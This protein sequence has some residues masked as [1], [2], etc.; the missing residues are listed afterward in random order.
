MAL[1]YPPKLHYLGT[2]FME[3]P[4]LRQL[5]EV[6]YHCHKQPNAFYTKYYLSN[7]Q[8][9]ELGKAV[10]DAGLL[11]YEYYLRMA[12]IGTVPMTDETAALY[13]GWNTRKVRRYRRALEKIGWYANVRYSLHDGRKGMAYYIGK[14]TVEQHLRKP[15][16]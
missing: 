15:I 1:Q 7:E 16:P 3:A 13:F 8:R 6:N 2:Q 10:G 5:D 14:P 11:L 12:A 9:V 4:T